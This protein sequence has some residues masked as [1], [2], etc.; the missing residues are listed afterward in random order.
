MLAVVGDSGE[1]FERGPSV[2][3][4]CQRA[5]GRPLVARRKAASA[6]SHGDCR[7]QQGSGGAELHLGGPGLGRAEDVDAGRSTSRAWGSIMLIYTSLPS[8]GLP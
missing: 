2:L 3:G 4:L 8:R 5:G 1:V 7:R 6:V